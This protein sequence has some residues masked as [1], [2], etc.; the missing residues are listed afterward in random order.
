MV[1]WRNDERKE[2][3]NNEEVRQRRKEEINEVSTIM[4]CPRVRIDIDS[5]FGTLVKEV[6]KTYYPIKTTSCEE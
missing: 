6:V 5:S 4:W 3:R 2:N 1:V